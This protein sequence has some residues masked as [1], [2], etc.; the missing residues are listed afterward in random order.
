MASKHRPAIPKHSFSQSVKQFALIDVHL[1]PIH[2]FILIIS[3]PLLF[4]IIESLTGFNF[5]GHLNGFFDT[6]Q[7]KN[8]SIIN[9]SNRNYQNNFEAWFSS[10]IGLRGYFIRLYNQIQFS[11]FNLVPSGVVGANGNIFELPYIDA[12]CGLTAKFDF[13]DSTQFK[14]LEEYVNHLESIQNKLNTIGK[15]L[16]FIITPSKAAVNF[17][18]IPL[19]YRLKRKSN[20]ISPYF[21][22]KKEL[23]HKDINLIDSRSLFSTNE[24]PIFYVTGIHWARPIEQ[25]FSQALVE[26]MSSLTKQDLPKISL[27]KL[28]IS[29]TPFLRDADIFNNANTILKPHGLYYE[30]EATIDSSSNS[31]KP[32]FLIQSGSFAEGFYFFDYDNLSQDSYKFFYNK[33]FRKKRNPGVSMTSWN[34]IDFS[35]IL[36]E[37]D[38]VIIE[39]NEAY[40]PNFNDG[41]VEYLDSFLDS[42]KNNS[43]TN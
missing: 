42:Y 34:D 31:Q 41:F 30:Y 40:I 28:N 23:S 37:I 26:K 9:Y 19:K 11:F 13:S 33:I 32:R 6:P 38:I 3:L 1:P 5:K 12:E 20:F 8:F 29:N 35:E 17:N 2:P 4:S 14:K 7:K 10:N 16:V 39:T 25:R 21:Y 18:D 24:T 22:L 15:N 27:G 43:P 36:N